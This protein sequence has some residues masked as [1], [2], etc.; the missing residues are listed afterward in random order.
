[1]DKEEP[2]EEAMSLLDHL[3]ELRDRLFRAVLALVVGTVIGFALAEPALRAVAERVPGQKFF[4]I[5]PTEGLTNYFMISVT[6]GAALAMPMILY[7]IIAFIMTILV[8]LLSGIIATPI[9]LMSGGG[10]EGLAAYEG[11]PTMAIL[12]QAGPAI[13]AWVVL[14]AL[15]SALQLAVMYAPFSAAYRDL[16]GLPI[17]P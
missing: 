16:K 12:Q 4:V 10:I 3:R 6:I 17:E 2:Q 8:S 7:Q 14:N 13:A 1:M 11:Q 9:T 5:N 15:F